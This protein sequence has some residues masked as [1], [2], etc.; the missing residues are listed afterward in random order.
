MFLSSWEEY[1]TG[2]LYLGVV[3]GPVE[4]ILL[5]VLN[6]VV[7]GLHP[8]GAGFWAQT[9]LKAFGFSLPL[10][11]S[12]TQ[13]LDLMMLGVTV[14]FLVF[15]L[16]PCLLNV[17]RALETKRSTRP[18]NGVRLTV[19]S[20][21]EAASQ[22]LPIIAFSVLSAAWTLS[23]YSVIIKQQYMLEWAVVTC[24]LF[25]Q[26]STKIVLAHLCKGPFPYSPVLLLPLAIGAVG[27]NT[28]WLGL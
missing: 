27:V 28:P 21:A 5:A 8:L 20:T 16:P 25:G 4:G 1:H 15:H 22:L 11:P 6:L 3:N 13:L 10:F 7:S 12:G 23:P 18:L 9:T 2:T 24:F 17:H 14:L 19:P 26:L